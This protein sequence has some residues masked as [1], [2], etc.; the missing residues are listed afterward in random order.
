MNKIKLTL[1]TAICI[2]TAFTF[3][4]CEEKD[5]KAD[6]GGSE[7]K[8]TQEEASE[9]ER[10]C[11]EKTGALQTAEATFGGTYEGQFGTYTSNFS[12]ANGNEISLTHDYDDNNVKNLKE[13]DKVS[14]TYKEMQYFTGEAGGCWNYYALESVKI[15]NKGGSL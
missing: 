5:K 11:P 14:I 2:A 15:I 13:D 10:N 4:A 6:S 8:A 12:L 7:A 1:L 3:L 9:A